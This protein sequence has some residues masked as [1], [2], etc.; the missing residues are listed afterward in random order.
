MFLNLGLD[1]G[2]KQNMYR[3]YINYTWNTARDENGNILLDEDGNY[4]I[5]GE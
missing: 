2:V 5:L 3:P 4:I 1:F